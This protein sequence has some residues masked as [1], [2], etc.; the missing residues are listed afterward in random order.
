MRSAMKTV[1][2]EGSSSQF[3]YGSASVAATMPATQ[4][5][6]RQPAFPIIRLTGFLASCPSLVT[7]LPRA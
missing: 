3:G 2:A 5:A 7:G 4:I 1:A 6:T